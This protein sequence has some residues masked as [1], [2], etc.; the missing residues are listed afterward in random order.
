MV[1][2]PKNLD[3]SEDYVEKWI[4][5]ENTIMISEFR[6]IGSRRLWEDSSNVTFRPCPLFYQQLVVSYKRDIEFVVRIYG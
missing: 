4:P 3:Q 6:S 1:G 2:Y 5:Y